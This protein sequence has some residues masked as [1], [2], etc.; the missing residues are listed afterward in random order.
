MEFEIVKNENKDIY[1]DSCT[2]GKFLKCQCKE[3]MTSFFSLNF[4]TQR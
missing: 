1:Y 4:I 2:S 3:E